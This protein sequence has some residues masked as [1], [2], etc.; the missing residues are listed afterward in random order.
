MGEPRSRTEVPIRQASVRCSVQ[1]EGGGESV[2]NRRTSRYCAKGGSTLTQTRARGGAREK[3]SPSIDR[4]GSPC[5]G[6]LR[7]SRGSCPETRSNQKISDKGCTRNTK[8]RPINSRISLAKIAIKNKGY[9]QITRPNNYT[10]WQVR[11]QNG[12]WYLKGTSKW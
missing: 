11:K 1:A 4:V 9:K 2:A 5:S 6:T 10:T 8:I 7:H 3:R 12:Q